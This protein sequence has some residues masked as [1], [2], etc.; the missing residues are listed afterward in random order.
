MVPDT[1]TT[2]AATRRHRATGFSL[3]E[4]L[5]SMT[6]LIALLTLLFGV[7]EGAAR[8]WNR[9]EQRRAPLREAGA[10]LH[11]IERDLRGAVIT[12]DPETLRILM[13]PS[14]ESGDSL[15]FLVC[16]CGKEREGPDC[17]GLCATGFFTACAPGGQPGRNLYRYH[18]S[19]TRVL[20]ALRSGSLGRLY[21][22]ASV[23]STNTELLARHVERL[24]CRPLK[25]GSGSPGELLVTVTAVDPSLARELARNAEN[26]DVLLQGK[27]VRLSAVIPL[28]KLR[29][30][31][32]EP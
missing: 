2:G 4:L 28:P 6:I 1:S 21:S 27:A 3:L 10:A 8:F 13:E 19:G 25:T 23:G 24:D 32:P 17:G 30:T 31:T 22:S 16:H 11:L 5:V 12:S 20:E 18:A 9:A 29:E 15:F 26:R 14:P 7:S